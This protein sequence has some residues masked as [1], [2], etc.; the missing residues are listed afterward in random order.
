MS[1]VATREPNVRVE[2]GS[3]APPARRLFEP[4]SGRTLEDSILAVW[5]ELAKEDHATCPVCSGEMTRAGGCD[6]CG[7]RLS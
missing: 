1:A 6:S 5:Q 4:P 7:S 2:S 3:S